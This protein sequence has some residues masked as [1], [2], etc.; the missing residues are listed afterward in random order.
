[1]FAFVDDPPGITTAL[2]AVAGV[3]QPAA[4]LANRGPKGTKIPRFGLAVT[5]KTG[6]NGVVVTDLDAKGPAA[7]YGFEVGDVI[8]ELAAKKVSNVGEIR[9][10]IR[11]AEKSGRRRML[12][13]VKSGDN[14]RYVTRPVARG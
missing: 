9:D 10:A 1:V 12:M 2:S 4:T 14:S 5:S 6:S 7:D 11:A 3:V 8:L 13:G